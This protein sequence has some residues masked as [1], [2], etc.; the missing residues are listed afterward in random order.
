MCPAVISNTG[1]LYP[2]V[3]LAYTLQ[4]L[5]TPYRLLIP[6]YSPP[7]NPGRPLRNLTYPGPRLAVPSGPV[8]LALSP[9]SLWGPQTVRNT[10]HAM[11][12]ARRH[13]SRCLKNHNL[14]YSPRLSPVVIGK[15]AEPGY[16]I[17]LTGLSGCHP[18]SC[19]FHGRIGRTSLPRG[20]PP[21]ISSKDL[22]FLKQ[23]EEFRSF[24]GRRKSATSYPEKRKKYTSALG[25]QSENRMYSSL[26]LGSGSLHS[27][28]TGIYHR[29]YIIDAL[30]TK[31]KSP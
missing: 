23:C 19:R 24:R 6:P 31:T 22:P 18:I 9:P 21:S 4:S 8:F 16:P 30:L 1:R 29:S 28:D 7:H 14:G 12:V 15:S 17:M 27:I 2:P 3:V 20:N 13:N 10:A 5:P 25:P 11:V 26:S